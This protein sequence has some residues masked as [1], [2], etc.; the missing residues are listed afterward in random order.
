MAQKAPNPF[1]EFDAPAANPFDEF[2][3]APAAP[4]PTGTADA[5]RAGAFR[6]VR[7][8]GDTL[9]TAAAYAIDKFGVSPGEAVAWAAENVSGFSKADADKIR[10]NLESL[11]NFSDVVSAGSKTNQMREATMYRDSPYAYGGGR[12]LGQVA[13]TAPVPG[14]MAKPVAKLAGGTM[15]G[16]AIATALASSGFKTGLLP[17]RA[18]IKEGLEQAPALVQRLTDLT[19]RAIGGGATGAAVGGLTGSSTDF[20]AAQDIG[21]GFALGALMPTAGS[22]AFR[23]VYDKVML[24]FYERVTGQ[25]GAQRA[26]AIFRSAFNM[27]IQQALTLARGAQGDT[28]F[29][30]VVADTGANEPTLQALNK[31]VTEGAGSQ[32]LGPV[33]RAEIAAEQGVLN[34]MARGGTEREARN[35]FA[36]GRSA[37]GETYGGAQ[38]QVFNRVNQNT[39]QV[40]PLVSQAAQ[41][42]REAARQLALA[43]G[44][45]LNSAASLN[46]AAEAERLAAAAAAARQQIADLE[47]QGVRA[48]ETGPL[49]AQIRAMAGAEGAGSAQ[50]SALNALADDVAG[51]GPVIRAGDLD[52]V[53]RNANVT[54]AKALGSVDVGGLKAQTAEALGRVKNIFDTAMGPEYS[55]AKSDFALGATELERQAFT[56]KLAGTFEGGPAGQT[57]V[58]RTI[59]GAPGTTATV[60]AAFPKSGSRNFDIQ[61]MMG[62]PGG[63]AGPSRM[64]ALENI[65]RNV[66]TRNSMADQAVEGAYN[67]NQLLKNPP[68]EADIF[69]RM[70][71]IGMIMNAGTAALKFAKIMSESGLDDATQRRLAE[72]LR[73][74]QSAEELLLTIPLADRVQLRRRL[75]ANGLLNV[76]SAAGISGVNA[77]NTRPLPE[78][79]DPMLDYPMTNYRLEE[80]GLTGTVTDTSRPTFGP[81]DFTPPRINNARPRR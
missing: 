19:V 39:Q 22:A 43:R 27:P 10:R 76:K 37:I 23:S 26:A 29:A 73:N 79:D 47:A 46:A 45:P 30:R 56:G 78:I 49:A 31:T 36:E 74:G 53:R 52:A 24:P 67:S 51:Y 72:G 6:G 66:E 44:G 11:P 14:L 57:E 18:A 59:R 77:L 8:V 42:E 80:E 2:D 81:Y 3:A 70:S 75:T 28:P 15:L 1:D 71:P 16:D 55:A 63:A 20:T 35:A 60:E 65:A 41:A 33:N 54:I 40:A 48:L 21:L 13:A 69:N 9:T 50:Q 34:S 7:D 32:I 58:A 68:Q 38:T 17:T 64:P 25:L 4:P 12:I 62:V 61:E 5:T